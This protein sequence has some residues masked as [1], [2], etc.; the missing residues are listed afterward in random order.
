MNVQIHFGHFGRKDP[1]STLIFLFFLFRIFH[2]GRNSWACQLQEFC[3]ESSFSSPISPFSLLIMQLQLLVRKPL[4][5]LFIIKVFLIFQ[6]GVQRIV[7]HTRAGRGMNDININTHKG[8]ERHEWHLLG[9]CA[10]QSLPGNVEF[11]YQIC[12]YNLL[13]FLVF[14]M[15][16]LWKLNKL[17]KAS[18][19]PSHIQNVNYFYF[20]VSTVL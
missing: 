13:K 5:H 1:F 15:L 18:S 19:F 12:V 16:C 17:L 7:I 8:R 4:L 2:F 6:S 20:L 11:M 3:K 14:F 9:L 10:Q